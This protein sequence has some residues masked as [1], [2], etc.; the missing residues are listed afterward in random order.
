MAAPS[1]Y[2]FSTALKWRPN[3]E[4]SSRELSAV[5][6][7][8]MAADKRPFHLNP[9]RPMTYVALVTDSN[10]YYANVYGNANSWEQFTDYLEELGCQVIENQTEDYEN[11]NEIEQDCMSIDQLLESSFSKFV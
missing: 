3:G 8:V 2:L 1:D 4:L 10:G 7:L 5:H 9:T 6:A 11:D